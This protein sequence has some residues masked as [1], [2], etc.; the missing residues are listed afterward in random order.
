[1]QQANKAAEV[2]K[3]EP[4]LPVPPQPDEEQYCFGKSGKVEV[5][6]CSFVL[7]LIH[8]LKQ[9]NSLANANPNDDQNPIHDFCGQKDAN[10]LNDYNHLV[11]VHGDQLEQICAQLI[12]RRQFETCDV[13]KCALTTRHYDNRRR[14][15]PKLSNPNIDSKSLFFQEIF[16]SIHY[17]IFH[18]FDV[19]LRTK[20]NDSVDNTAEEDNVDDCID[21]QLRKLAQ[22]AR[23]KREFERFGSNKFN[24]NNTVEVSDDSDEQKGGVSDQKQSASTGSFNIGLIFYYWPFYKSVKQLPVADVEPDN[25]N[26]HGGYNVYELFV[27]QKYR[28]FKEEISNYDHVSVNAYHAVVVKADLYRNTDIAKRLKAAESRSLHYDI[29]EGSP[30]NYEYLIALILYC[31]FSALCTDFSSTFRPTFAAESLESIKKRNQKYWWLSKLLRETVQIYGYCGY[32]HDEANTL[33]GPWYCGMTNMIVANFVC[34][35]CSP[36]SASQQFAVAVR[37]SG[38]KGIIMQLN[39]TSS[40]LLRGFDCSWISSFREEDERLFMG[41][42]YRMQIESVRDMKTKMNYY[43][44]FHALSYFDS[45]LSGTRMEG[46]V[47]K[48]DIVALKALMKQEVA[49][50]DKCKLPEYVLKAFHLFCDNKI[51]IAINLPFVDDFG[52][53]ELNALILHSVVR[54]DS[55]DENGINEA[56]NT[57]S[58]QN[59][60]NETVFKLFK[61]VK[62][63]L[64]YTS[65]YGV[66]PFSV[67]S[68]MAIMDANTNKI[69]RIGIHAS[70]DEYGGGG[71]SWLETLWMEK[72]K[73]LIASKKWNSNLQ[74]N[75]DQYGDRKVS[76][77][78]KSVDSKEKEDE[79]ED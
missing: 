78:M 70:V 31:D 25:V 12:A 27:Q 8:D 65:G 14:D 17:Y 48:R 2:P 49:P 23:Q 58:S 29:A 10:V 79:K 41:G 7:R 33:Q 35:L 46:R 40:E 1:M 72:S 26:D 16:D 44:F 68:L 64:I 13:T 69:Q 37:F 19:G 15:K 11:V 55:E 39:N 61:N 32:E 54:F 71:R 38:D 6:K 50:T 30:F 5:D 28:S 53:N 76:L 18:L 24:I 77:L 43:P 60:L 56:A 62:E 66:Y 20:Q 4:P 73:E 67:Q 22:D 3:E 51:Q 52:S 47:S 34:R 75:K 36:T 59:L 74:M 45:M 63:L 42:S 9:Y 57:P 21:A